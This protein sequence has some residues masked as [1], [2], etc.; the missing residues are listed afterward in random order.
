[1]TERE[2]FTAALSRE[3]PAQRAAFL[4]EQ[5]AGNPLLR[6]RIEALLAERSAIVEQPS[7]QQ[8]K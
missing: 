4:D 3:N 2:I 7:N 8:N 5:C 1:M 6:Q